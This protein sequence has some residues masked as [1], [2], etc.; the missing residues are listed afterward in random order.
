MKKIYFL[1][2]IAPVFILFA[3]A[4]IYVERH[5]ENWMMERT[6]SELA[7]QATTIAGVLNVIPVGKKTD[8]LD[9]FIDKLALKGDFRMTIIKDDGAVIADSWVATND[10]LTMK[11]HADRL[12]V[13]AARTTEVG[14][15][16]R[17]SATV[18]TQMY[19]LAIPLVIPDF[20]GF[21]RVAISLSAIQAYLSELHTMLIKAGLVGLF[22]LITIILVAVRYI[23]RINSRHSRELELKVESRTKDIKRI[24]TLGQ[25][26]AGCENVE[27]ICEVVRAAAPT[28][29]E[30]ESGAIS[31]SNSAKGHI[32]IIA[33]WG[34]EWHPNQ[35]Y[36]PND[37]WAVRRGTHHLSDTETLGFNCKHFDSQNPVLCV[38]IVSQ[39]VSLGAIHIMSGQ[40]AI[41]ARL[42]EMTL[43]VAE[44]L[45]LSIANVNL[46]D[47]LKHQ[48]VRDPLTNLYNRR[49]LD[50]SLPRELR[51]AARSYT[52]LGLMMID[53]DHFK[54]FNDTFGHDAGDYV[55][56]QLGTE[57]SHSI[58]SEDIACRYG[59]EEFIIVV[60][61]ADIA[62][63][64]RRANELL[65]RVRT[66]ELTFADKTLGYITL[67]IG[68][69]LYPH[70]G[71]TGEALIS[72]ADKALYVAKHAG[73]D[74][75]E[76]AAYAANLAAES[77]S[78]FA[79][80]PWGEEE[81]GWE[82]TEKKTA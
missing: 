80:N 51:R 59:G 2:F 71:D 8:T 16:I 82:E 61:D 35:T 55:L 15:A 52:S 41:P 10:V 78:G 30:G 46:R 23:E 38:P 69:A 4:S 40:G 17:L 36:L 5:L 62:E 37:C 24:Q 32:E 47:S 73:R 68:I 43:S 49:Y 29:F 27:E 19:Y 45:S 14:T 22:L 26:L 33:S 25:M 58:N 39:G 6:H 77:T 81:I 18:N 72:V 56:Q 11:N 28:I 65:A 74:R 12:E 64:T 21:I 67:S 76:V 20:T 48:A 13:Q 63:I 1:V 66:K 75:V 3:A 9:P 42:H 60:P 53:V 70:H 50:E 31:I 54:K 7:R 34:D 44:H 57:F 79:D